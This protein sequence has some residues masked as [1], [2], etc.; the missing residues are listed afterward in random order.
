MTEVSFAADF[1]RA[2]R[3]D[4]LKRV[5]A[6]LKGADFNE[7][8]TWIS[9]DGYRYEPL[10]G[11]QAGPRAARQAAVPWT[12]VQRVDHPDAAS[13]NAQALEDLNNGAT[14][15]SL[16][17]SDA[18]TARGFG[19]DASKLARVLK[20]VQLHAI[21]LRVEGTGAEALA[22]LIAQQP[23]DPERLTVSF[24]ATSAA[25]AKRLSA[26]G[27]RGPLLEADGRPWHEKG[28]TAGEE[29]GAVLGEVAG[30]LRSLEALG[31]DALARAVG[32]SLAADQDLFET[33]AKFRAMRLLWARVLEA[34]GLPP[35]ELALHA[36]TSWRMQA[37][38]DPHTNILRATAAVFG[39]GLGGTSSICVLPF[40]L[41]QGL[42]NAFARRVARH[43]QTVLI[44][45]ANLWRV[46]DAASGAGY[47]E[48]MT[49]DLCTAAWAVFQQTE[50][51][52][53][54]EARPQSTHSL[55]VI[56]T[57]AYPLP[58]EHPAEVEA[59]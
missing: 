39:A 56:G 43:V 17:S 32:V 8:L 6:V 15:L 7:K 31:D 57:S 22:A 11:Q 24:A 48:Q 59:V 40:S 54:P 52:K 27:F 2:S 30:H 29:L 55:A 26:Q 36:E 25:V 12:V 33:L 14:G 42:P 46:A 58:T 16:V 3:E 5:D 35:A 9:G 53:W 21:A 51:G 45:E 18:A 37:V 10:Y 41:A 38:R 49:H 13:A 1:P 50:R 20:G 4:W 19:F 34:C 47:V 23:V 28:A 44:E